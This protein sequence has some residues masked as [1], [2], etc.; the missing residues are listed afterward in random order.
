[1]WKA[2]SLAQL[3]RAS[4][5][6]QVRGSRDG[7]RCGE[8][9]QLAALPAQAVWV[10]GLEAEPAQKDPWDQS[11]APSPGDWM[12]YGLLQALLGARESFQVS[13]VGSWDS[14]PSVV[15][16]LAA[17]RRTHPRFG[18]VKREA[19]PVARSIRVVEPRN[20][21]VRQLHR[22]RNN[23]LWG[24]LRDGLGVART[25]KER[26]IPFQEP[27]P[28]LQVELDPRCR[29]PVQVSPTLW[30]RPA[31]V[32]GETTIVGKMSGESL[33]AHLEI[34]AGRL[35]DYLDYYQEALRS[36][37]P[38]LPDAVSKLLKGKEWQGVAEKAWEETLGHVGA[39]PWEK[40][41]ELWAE[42][43]RRLFEEV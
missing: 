1:M 11:M 30:V 43:G 42:R 19:P 26:L 17:A 3:L 27:A 41:W 15:E 7:V 32:V 34:P 9:R 36:P 6:S 2:K 18:R 20:V 5:R 14:I 33:E 24:Y 23:P 39:H 13:F 10:L 29:K 38:L 4:L 8:L 16:E 35:A 12:R 40:E 37:S 28:T 31:L 21:D 22:M 25:W